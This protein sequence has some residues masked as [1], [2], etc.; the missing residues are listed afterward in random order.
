M[1]ANLAKRMDEHYKTFI[2]SLGR[3]Q[4]LT[5]RQ[6]RTLPTLL[7]LVSTGSGTSLITDAT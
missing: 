4:E 1:G 6:R 2:A 3:T 7:L 5:I